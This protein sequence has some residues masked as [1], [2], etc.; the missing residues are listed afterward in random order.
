M[1]SLVKAVILAGG[2]GRRLRPLTYYIQK[3]MIPIGSLEKP[4]LEYIVRLLVTN[5]IKDIVVLLGYKGGQV[6]NYFGD[7]SR[8]GARI[9]YSFD[10]ENYRGSG[11]ALLKSYLN[12]LLSDANDVLV[13]YGDILAD[14][15]LRRLIEHHRTTNADATLLVTRGYQVP[16]GIASV[17]EDGRI[18]ELKEKPWL[19]VN[20]TIGILMLK[21]RVIE[22]LREIHKGS[23][24]IMGDFI[25]YLIKRGLLV[26]AFVYE[27]KWYDIGSIERYEK[28]DKNWLEELTRKLFSDDF[29]YINLLATPNPQYKKQS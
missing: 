11:G 5:G 22:L 23:T 29:E 28:I 26:K 4:L 8:L 2:E 12:G 18:L 21:T 27:G 6:V 17:D 7:G 19:P 1:E 3:A 15:D 13:Y 24:D 14:L 9:S 10:D 16:V 25:P 20:A